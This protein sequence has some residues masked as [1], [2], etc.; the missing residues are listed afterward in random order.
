MRNLDAASTPSSFDRH[1]SLGPTILRVALGLVFV[2]HAW[3][4]L[5]VFTLPG[6]AAFFESQGF[7]GWT[8]YPVFAG[9]LVGGLALIAGF[10]TRW[11]ALALVP[12]MIGAVKPHLA[13]GWAFTNPGGGWEFPVFLIAALLAQAAIGSGAYAVDGLRARRTARA[14]APQRTALRAAA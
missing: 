6:T 13:A 3:T 9:E 2:A 8:A 7:P 11:A 5:T 4:K 14:T 10:K 1:A 12:I